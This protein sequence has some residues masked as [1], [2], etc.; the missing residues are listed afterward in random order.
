MKEGLL[1][2]MFLC[3]HAMIFHES[4]QHSHSVTNIASCF[5]EDTKQV[6]MAFFIFNV[7]FPNNLRASYTFVDFMVNVGH[8]LGCTIRDFLREIRP[9][10]ECITGGV[11]QC[12]RVI[13]FRTRT[14]RSK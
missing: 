10:S 7:Q 12:T 8:K 5:A 14:W 9:Y 4:R 6:F 13:I 1:Q 2:A 3:S 11:L